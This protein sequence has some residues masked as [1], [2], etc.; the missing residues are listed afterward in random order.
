MGHGVSERSPQSSLLRY[1]KSDPRALQHMSQR[2]GRNATQPIAPGT[3]SGFLRCPH[4][5]YK[6]EG[7]GAI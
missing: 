7:L 1:L 2:T 3:S 4:C 5:H 6:L